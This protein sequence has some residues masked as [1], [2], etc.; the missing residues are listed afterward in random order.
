MPQPA[1]AQAHSIGEVEDFVG[2]A[3][4]VLINVGTLSDDVSCRGAGV[5]PGFCVGQRGWLLPPASQFRSSSALS[6]CRVV[7]RL[8][9]GGG[10]ISR[11]EAT[12]Q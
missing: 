2:I 6:R 4:A 9:R 11:R 5:L 8:L 7:L 1:R 12:R 3:S 10:C